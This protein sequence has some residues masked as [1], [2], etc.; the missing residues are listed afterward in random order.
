MDKIWAERKFIDTW[1]INHFLFGATLPLILQKIGFEFWS[2]FL[3]AVI[4]FIFW[5]AIEKFTHESESGYNG[6]FDII[7]A[8]VGFVS[9]WQVHNKISLL[10]VIVI[11]SI[12]ETFGYG[13]RVFK[14]LN[15]KSRMLGLLWIFVVLV[16]LIFY[17]FALR[18][19]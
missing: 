7:L 17:I 6:I 13:R 2:S 5:E 16:Y 14:S 18:S 15:K 19:L 11:F 10:L 12:L 1:S 9:F 8:T 3:I 4:L